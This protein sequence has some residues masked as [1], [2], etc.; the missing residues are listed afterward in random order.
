[1]RELRDLEDIRADDRRDGNARQ[2]QGAWA[3]LGQGRRLESLDEKREQGGEGERICGLV[4]AMFW[5]VVVLIVCL[6]ATGI[7]VGLG[8]GFGGPGS[9]CTKYVKPSYSEARAKTTDILISTS[10]Q[11]TVTS[12][13]YYINGRGAS[14][15]PSPPSATASSSASTF[16][17]TVTSTQR[18]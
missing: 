2:V 17:P 3:D 6:L 5:A 1:M 16:S 9:H 11:G 15:T 18:G 14:S 8:M 12:V 7:G 4:P 13:T 10:G